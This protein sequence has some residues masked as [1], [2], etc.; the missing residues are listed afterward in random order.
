MGSRSGGVTG[1]Y[2]NP[3]SYTTDVL[4][5]GLNRFFILA[6]FIFLVLICFVDPDILKTNDI[7]GRK[8]DLEILVSKLYDMIEFY[9]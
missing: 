9:N 3:D 8:V 5:L 2:A 4:F 6:L 1:E 7:Y